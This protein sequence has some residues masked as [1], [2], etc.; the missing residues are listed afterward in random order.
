MN[1]ILFVAAGAVLIAAFFIGSWYYKRD[2]AE[3]LGSMAQ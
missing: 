2:R 1:R 3:E